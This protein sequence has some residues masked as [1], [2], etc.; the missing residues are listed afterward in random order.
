MSELKT[1]KCRQYLNNMITASAEIEEQRTE[2]AFWSERIRGK[3][4][5]RIEP[6]IR[7]REEELT[8]RINDMVEKKL[9]MTRMIDAITDPIARTILRS[10]YVFG[11]KWSCIA[12]NCG[13][14][15]ERN[16]RYIH[17]NALFDFEEIFSHTVGTGA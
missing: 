7:R 5:T 6:E 17:D 8:L 2:L 14:M 1:L 12:E 10:R 16:A 15:S 3:E 11:Q 13:G 9:A 4:G